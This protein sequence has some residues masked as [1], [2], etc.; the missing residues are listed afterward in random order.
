MRADHD[1]SSKHIALPSLTG[2]GMA[3][4]RIRSLRCARLEQV[5]SVSIAG[6]SGSIPLRW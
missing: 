4:V 5:P 6:P 1:D 3:T 2:K